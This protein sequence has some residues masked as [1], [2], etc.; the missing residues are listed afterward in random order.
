[1]KITKSELKQIIKEEAERFVKITALEK[2][3]ANLTKQINEI[4]EEES[5]EESMEESEE[6]NLEELF[7]FGTKK[8]MTSDEAWTKGEAFVKKEPAKAKVYNLLD[9]KDKKRKYLIFYGFN[10]G[11]KYAVWDDSLEA[12]DGTKGYFKDSTKYGGPG[13]QSGMNES[14]IRK[15]AKEEVEKTKKI[16]TLKERAE[17]IAQELKNL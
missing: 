5:M 12:P 9:T 4:Y 15:I 3:K 2:K 7:G 1:M 17:K 11:V 14:E 16:E 6:E 13:L 8:A 10:P